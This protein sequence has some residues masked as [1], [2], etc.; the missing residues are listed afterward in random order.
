MHTQ[1]RTHSRTHLMDAAG[2]PK[3]PRVDTT[4]L[5]RHPA[6]KISDAATA[7]FHD[8]ATGRHNGGSRRNDAKQRGHEILN[9][10]SVGLHGRVCAA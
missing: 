1:S 4:H 3:G 6:A 5:L 9:R 10:R 8:K 2:T 7:R